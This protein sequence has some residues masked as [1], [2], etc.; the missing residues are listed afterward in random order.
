MRAASMIVTAYKQLEAE[1]AP[2][3]QYVEI[4]AVLHSMLS[5]LSPWTAHQQLYICPCPVPH[6]L[7]ICAGGQH[8]SNGLQAAAQ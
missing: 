7:M 1:N 5:C 8:D 2:S 3:T 4:Q 6:T